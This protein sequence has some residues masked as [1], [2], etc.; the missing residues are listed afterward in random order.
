MSQIP[1]YLLSEFAKTD[2]KV[3]LSGDGGDELFSGYNRHVFASTRWN[4]IQ[5]VPLIVRAILAGSI[6]NISPNTWGRIYGVLG[7]FIDEEKKIRLPGEKFHKLADSLISRNIEELY[8][9]L[10]QQTRNVRF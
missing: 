3:C 6:S 7:H 9:N 10:T 5:K 1:T 2:L 8:M 4:S